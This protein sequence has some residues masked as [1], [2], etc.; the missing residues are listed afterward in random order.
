M[1]IMF[2]LISFILSIIQDPV[3]DLYE[4]NDV[5]QGVNYVLSAR[6]VNMTWLQG[7]QERLSFIG[8]KLL[9]KKTE[10]V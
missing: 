6:S 5:G 1:Q 3:T 10:Y 9:F 4:I 2:I 7:E 8:A